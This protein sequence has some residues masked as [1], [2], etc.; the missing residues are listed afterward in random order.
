MPDTTTQQDPVAPPTPKRQSKSTTW[1]P[2]TA[3]GSDRTTSNTGNPRT[4]NERDFSVYFDLQMEVEESNKKEAVGKLKDIATKFLSVIQDADPTAILGNFTSSNNQ[5]ALLL[6]EKT[7]TTVTKLGQ[8]FMRARPNPAGGVVYTAVRIA[9]N[10]EESNLMRNTEFELSDLNIRL[11][12]RPLQVK[13]TVRKG[14]FCGVPSGVCTVA[15]QGVLMAIMREQQIK[16]LSEREIRNTEPIVMALRRQVV[17][18]GKKKNKDGDGGQKRWTTKPKAIHIEFPKL[19]ASKGTEALCKAIKS[20]MFESFYRGSIKFVPLFD[21]NVSDSNKQK[22]L[23]AITRHGHLEQSTE[24]F[25]IIGLVNMDSIDKTTGL[26]PRQMAMTFLPSATNKQIPLILSL[27]PKFNDYET[28][29]ATVPV[30]VREESRELCVNFGANLRRKFGNSVLQFFTAEKKRDILASVFDETTQKF[31]NTIDQDLDDLETDLPAYMLD[32]SVLQKADEQ[33][34][35]GNDPSLVRQEAKHSGTIPPGTE[36]QPTQK[37]TGTQIEHTAAPNNDL[38]SNCDSMSTFK[39][40]VNAPIYKLPDVT[41]NGAASQPASTSLPTKISTDETSCFGDDM[42]QMTA[43]SVISRFEERFTS[44]EESINHTNMVLHEILKQ[45]KTNNG[46]SPP[47][48]KQSDSPSTDRV[49]SP[50]LD[51]SKGV[52]GTCRVSTDP[53]KGD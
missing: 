26:T 6:P 11:F 12:R 38:V 43:A 30:K 49:S 29:I 8:F 35:S 18:D 23:K 21:Y 46:G 34:D 1:H 53:P 47:A 45:L 33:N 44:N 36:V 40:K 2:D 41:V 37:V 14:W 16:G 51:K 3:N 24:Q 19:Q 28:C 25:E 13:E 48:T 17:Y 27:D 50:D 7:P 15:L 22:I 39:S 9:F 10:G 5:R 20:M 31:L 4:A 42:T 32:L 52:S